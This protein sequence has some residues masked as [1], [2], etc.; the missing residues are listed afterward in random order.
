MGLHCNESSDKL[1][2]GIEAYYDVNDQN[3]ESSLLFSEIL[4]EHQLNHFKSRGV[5]TA[6]LFLLKNTPTV[7]GIIL[8]LGFLTNEEDR[9]IL[10]DETK[11]IEI[12]KS[13]YDALLEIRN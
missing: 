4:I 5:K 11:Q 12:A 8:E 9:A 10:T 7:P 6:N 1:A 2:N 3:E 13:I